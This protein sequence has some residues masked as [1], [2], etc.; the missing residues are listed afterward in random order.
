MGIWSNRTHIF[1]MGWFNHQLVA[2][3]PVSKKRV[4]CITC[5]TGYVDFW[6]ADTHIMCPSMYVYIQRYMTTTTLQCLFDHFWNNSFCWNTI[7][8]KWT[9][10]S[11]TCHFYTGKGFFYAENHFGSIVIA[12]PVA[13]EQKVCRSL[14]R[15]QQ[16]ELFHW[17]EAV[18][19]E[20]GTE[21]GSDLRLA[22]STCYGNKIS[23]D[24]SVNLNVWEIFSI[25]FGTL[26]ISSCWC[27]KPST[28]CLLHWNITPG[29]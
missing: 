12:L 5:L 2:S 3:A 16:C 8:K 25:Q 15:R 29:K 7:R 10:L 21:L 13:V 26:E 27:C 18:G 19:R 1:Q 24:G 6:C 14:L 22:P 20:W 28:L 23:Q 9:K 17:S 4:Q 11:R